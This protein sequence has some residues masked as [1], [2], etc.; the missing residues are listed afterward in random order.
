[1]YKNIIII[2]LIVIFNVTPA[3]SQGILNNGS[4]I[5]LTSGSYLKIYGSNAN[6]TNATSGT[7]GTIDNE[8]TISL[9]G[10]W[11]NN[12]SNNVFINLNTSGEVIFNGTSAQTIGGT[13]K[14]IFEKFTINNSTGII[15]NV[16]QDIIST[17]DLTSGI[18]TTTSSNIITMRAGSSVSGASASNFVKGPMRKV[19]N[20]SFIFPVGDGLGGSFA[21]SPI[22]I[23]GTL[24]LTDTFTAQYN[25][26]SPPYP[27]WFTTAH[28]Y[29]TNLDHVSDQEWWNIQRGVSSSSTPDVTLYWENIVGLNHGITDLTDLRLAHWDASTSRW[30]D[31]GGTGIGN[32]T[33]G[34]I[35]N[36]FAFTNYS[37]VTYG[38]KGGTNPLPIELINFNVKCVENSVNVSW[39]TASETNNDYF[40]IEKSI[41]TNDWE[42][43]G[44]VKGAGNSNTILN[45]SFS[46]N[47]SNDKTSYC[48]LK[49]TDFD[50]NFKY[51]DY[52]AADCNNNLSNVNIYPNPTSDY[53]F[54]ETLSNDL[55][56]KLFDLTGNLIY[57]SNS[58]K[59]ISLSN[60]PNGFYML[61]LKNGNDIYRKKISVVK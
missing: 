4:K 58:Q 53:I 39:S 22:E 45:Y 47:N 54:I 10:N 30:V 24:A 52:S 3:V 28:L 12:A 35:K 44:I 33:T 18:I 38:S 50:G 7:D 59:I 23:S 41:N 36:S 42:N 20:T 61:S 43:I 14:T 32:T 29:T 46:D 1:M 9:Q 51:S 26:G 31:M 21:Y 60:L 16:P 57:E 8:G 6:Y 11:T 5:V 27:W 19:G 25:T 2:I 13:S 37:P 34:S 49:Q 55:E 15:L 56:V 40:T 48:R 17:L